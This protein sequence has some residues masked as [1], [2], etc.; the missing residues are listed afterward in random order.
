VPTYERSPEFIRNLE[1]LTPEQRKAFSKA[2]R[3]G[4]RVKGIRGAEGLFEMT[5]AKDG[6]AIFG[7]GDSIRA[8]E[9]HI[10]WLAVGS[11]DILK[12]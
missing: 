3:K 9:P 5:W 12:P 8:N 6:R 11:H 10:V 2:V 1:A 7:Y 4:L